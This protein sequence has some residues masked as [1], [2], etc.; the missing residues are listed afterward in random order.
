[1]TDTFRTR[2]VVFVEHPALPAVVEFGDRRGWRIVAETPGRCI[3]NAPREIVFSTGQTSSA[4]RLCEDDITQNS[5]AFAV[6]ATKG[7]AEALIGVLERA[8]P[9]WPLARLLME[10]DRGSGSTRKDAR[11]SG[12]LSRLRRSSTQPFSNAF[13]TAYTIPRNGCVPSPSG[14]LRTRRG[15]STGGG[16]RTWR[17]RIPASRSASAPFACLPRSTRHASEGAPYR[18]L[19]E[20]DELFDAAP[21][22]RADTH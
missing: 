9:S 7:E 3:E 17:P 2:R 21:E 14:R 12:S 6:G 13:A 10:V 22:L 1:M 11:S 18:V 4:V 5:Y 15:R 16:W 20:F 19:F 8:L